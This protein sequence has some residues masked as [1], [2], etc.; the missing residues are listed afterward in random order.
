MVHLSVIIVNYNVKYFLEQALLSVQKASQGLN[1]EVFVVD[2]N[3]SDGSVEMVKKRFSEVQIIDNQENTGF[4]VANNQAY[5]IA[6]GKYILLLNPDTVVAE[7]TFQICY[8]FMEK[9]PAAGALGVRMIDGSGTFLPESKRGFPSPFVAFCKTFG[10]ASLFPRSKFFNQY[11]LGH[12]GEFETCEIDVLAGAFM[13]MRKEA[14]EKVGMLD[15]AFFMYGEDIDLSYRIVKGGYKNYYLPTTSIIH[16]KGESTKKGSLNYVKTFY[17]AMI[18]FAKKHFT[19]TQGQFFVAMLQVAIYFRAFITLVSNLVKN[20][21]LPILDATLLF[22]GMYF[23]KDYWAISR[24]GDSSYYPLSLLFFNIPLYIIGWLSSVYFY[25]GYDSANNKSAILKGLTVGSIGLMA[26]YGLLPTEYRSS[27]ML[28]LLGSFFAVTVML[29]LRFLVHFIKYKN[30]DFFKTS[31]KNLIIIGSKEESERVRQL[32]FKAQIQKNFIGT[33]APYATNDFSTY[34]NS[35][36]NI[37]EVVSIYH[38]SEIIFCSKDVANEVIIEKMKQFGNAISYKIVSQDSESIIG[39]SSKDEVG[40]LYL[41]EI[42][43]NIASAIQRRNKRLFDIFSSFIL[44]IISP[45]GVFFVKNKIHFLQNTISVLFGK[46]TWISYTS[47]T[48]N[49]PRLKKGVL[50]ASSHLSNI[51]LNEATLQRIDYFY[52]KDYLVKKDVAIFWRAWRKM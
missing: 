25:G 19:G 18:I 52:A 48:K 43:F 51:E 22:G 44:L 34:L 40:E 1:V 46:K 4:A 12:L 24:F 11:Y 21:S 27:R 33:L 5:R 29:G 15:E 30:I 36:D 6:T 32:M 42:Q 50:A 9:N 8:D 47:A 16:Y 49:L 2:N 45:L 10:L 39:S 7:N 31:E 37:A 28:L 17:Q 35:L 38:I 14:L 20:W 23:L 41:S 13:Y 26:I 3:S